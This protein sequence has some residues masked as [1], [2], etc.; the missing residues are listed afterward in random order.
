MGP[1]EFLAPLV[2]ISEAFNAGV[3]AVAKVLVVAAFVAP[4]IWVLLIHPMPSGPWRWPVA[5]W[6][7]PALSMV[8][9]SEALRGG[10]REGGLFSLFLLGAWLG[11]VLVVGLP[12]LAFRAARFLLTGRSSTPGWADRGLGVMGLV[13]AGVGAVGVLLAGRLG[14]LGLVALVALLA[15]LP[16]FQSTPAERPRPRRRLAWLM[17]TA[18]IGVATP[19]LVAS[20]A[21]LAVGNTPGG[22]GV[23]LMLVSAVALAVGV[24]SRW[25]GGAGPLQVPDVMPTQPLS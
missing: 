4:L 6:L 2:S 7:A 9:C 13:A 11:L 8:V 22:N 16:F 21:L 17:G 3:A 14:A 10:S 25:W 23:L 15:L 24:F 12:R 20:A 19:P 5:W 18:L 1:L